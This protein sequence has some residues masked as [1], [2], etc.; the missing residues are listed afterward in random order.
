V[1]AASVLVVATALCR[2]VITITSGARPAFE[3]L[4]GGG[5]SEATTAMLAYLHGLQFIS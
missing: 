5:Q 4:G 3:L 1:Q 2:R